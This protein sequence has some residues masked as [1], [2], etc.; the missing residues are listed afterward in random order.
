[1][2]TLWL[3]RHG[4][5]LDFVEPEWFE[6]ATYPYDPPL[7]PLGLTAATALA[8]ELSEVRFDRIFTSPFLRTIQT[9]HPL[10]RL[11]QIPIQLEWGLCEWLCEDWSPTLPATMPIEQLIADYP[12]I[13]RTYQSLLLPSYPETLNELDRRTIIIAQKLVQSN[14]E[15]I[16][17]IAHKGSILGITAALTEDSAWRSHHL[18]CAGMIKLVSDGNSWKQ[19]QIEFTG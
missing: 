12:Q 7:S 1:M 5:R 6:T 14:R 4:E 15:N 11:L 9:A 13:D 18:A 19:C 8:N 3:I 2:Q 17:I 16:L 10:A